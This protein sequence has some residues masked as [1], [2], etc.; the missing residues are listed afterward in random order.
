M[1]FLRFKN[2]LGRDK[3]LYGFFKMLGERRKLYIRYKSLAALN[4]LDGIFVQIKPHKLHFIRQFS[5]RIAR[6]HPK[7]RDIFAA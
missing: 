6:F 7:T 5:L 4:A 3:F 1:D 2:S